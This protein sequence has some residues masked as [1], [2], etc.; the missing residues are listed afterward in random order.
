MITLKNV[1]FQYNSEPILENISAVFAPGELTGIIGPS[2]AG[3][4][5]LI[6]LLLGEL[7]A[8]HG[9]IEDSSGAPLAV[10]YVPQLDSGERSFPLTVEEMV[11]L[12]AASFSKKRP[13]FDRT[14]KK[15][16]RSILNRLDIAELWDRRLNELSGGQFQRVLIARALMSQPTLLLLD[17]P[18]SGIDLNTRQQVLDLVDELRSEGLTII[19]TTHDLNWVASQLPRIICLNRTIIGDGSPL[20]VLTPAIVRE[21]YGSEM[22][23]IVHNNRPV[24]VDVAHRGEPNVV[25]H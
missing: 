3:K 19:L 17:E 2:G 8:T 10:G 11:L 15:T 9:S 18:T 14:E 4:T 20:E 13:W 1:G 22:D 12:G 7:R 21:T 24:V 16:A 5:T 25:F 6:R 23:V